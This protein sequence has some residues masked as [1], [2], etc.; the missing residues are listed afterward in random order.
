[1]RLYIYD[2][3]ENIENERLNIG[4]LIE[5]A[6]CN[7]EPLLYKFLAKGLIF[8]GGAAYDYV[9]YENE[10]SLLFGKAINRA[11]ELE[12]KHA[13]FPRILLDDYVAQEVIKHWK[14]SKDECEEYKVTMPALYAE[15][16]NIKENF[17]GEVAVKD[18]DGKYMHNF[19]R[20]IKT[21]VSITAFTH[22]SKS[23]FL[24]DCIKMCES[25][26]RKYKFVNDNISSKYEW[27][28]NY[29]LLCS[30]DDCDDVL[31]KYIE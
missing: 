17:E 24:L 27:L 22:K 11:Y 1:M 2:F 28:L 9:Y 7:L 10:R 13:K 6:L 18:S 14:C 4:A 20:R 19:L 30:I 15:I 31:F 5:V 16:G 3:K 21:K 12:S 26:I 23:E 25:E 29:V 8:R